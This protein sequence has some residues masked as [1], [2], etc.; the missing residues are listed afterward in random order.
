MLILSF[1][2]EPSEIPI[3]PRCSRSRIDDRKREAFSRSSDYR[4]LSFPMFFPSRLIK[5]R[6]TLR[7]VDRC[8]DTM[9][10]DV[11]ANENDEY[12]SSRELR[13]RSV[14]CCRISQS[15]KRAL[16]RVASCFLLIM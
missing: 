12:N 16:L 4:G 8:A 14:V 13:K 10:P 7:S 6:R 3:Y 1:F 2:F 15:S 5:P 9:N 11:T